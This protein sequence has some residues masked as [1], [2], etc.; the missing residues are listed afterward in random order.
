[1]LSWGS[2]D[3]VGLVNV[4]LCQGSSVALRCDLLSRAALRF[5]SFVTSWAFSRELLGSGLKCFG[6]N[7]MFRMVCFRMSKACP[8]LAG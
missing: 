8:V 7:G 6:S 1:M 4:G 3:L 5:A 2:L